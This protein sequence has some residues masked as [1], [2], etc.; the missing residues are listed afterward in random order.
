MNVTGVIDRRTNESFSNLEYP[1]NKYQISGSLKIGSF[2]NGGSASKFTIAN[3]SN[4][5][6]EFDHHI[7]NKL[8]KHIMV[9]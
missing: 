3:T 7:L 8:N 4:N 9:F 2:N 5:I 6:F 1:H